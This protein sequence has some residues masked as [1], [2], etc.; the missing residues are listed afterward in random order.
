ME[1]VLYGGEPL[2]RE[3]ERYV[4]RFLTLAASAGIPYVIRINLD[5]EMERRIRDGKL[6]IPVRPTEIHRVS[7]LNYRDNV[8]FANLLSLC[9]DGYV[10]VAAL[11]DNQVIAFYHLME[12]RGSFVPLLRNCDELSTLLFSLDGKTLSSC[13][14]SDGTDMKLGM[15]SPNFVIDPNID[16]KNPICKNCAAYPICGGGCRRMLRG[17]R[18]VD[19]CPI[20]NDILLMF[21]SYVERLLRR[22]A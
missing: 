17:C 5:Q 18:E 8:S 19:D 15:Y 12:G 9:L 1:I 3:N 21:D 22:A 14:E 10:D 6:S 4:G 16:K 13:N 20:Y 2:L 7:H 11:G